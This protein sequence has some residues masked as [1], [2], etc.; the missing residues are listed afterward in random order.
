M[1]R[2]QRC[3]P[4]VNEFLTVERRVEGL[5]FVLSLLVFVAGWW[6]LSS[7]FYETAPDEHSSLFVQAVN[8]NFAQRELVAVEEEKRPLPKEPEPVAQPEEVDV[9]LEQVVEVPEVEPDP[10]PEPEKEVELEPLLAEAQVWQE[11]S[12][13]QEQVDFNALDQWIHKEIDS[14]K[15]YPPAAERIGL[16]GIF[17]FSLTVNSGGTIVSAEVLEGKGHRMLRRALEGMLQ[18]LVGRSFGKSIGEAYEFAAEFEFE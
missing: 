1:C 8:L 10:E 12:S 15:Y 2:L 4:V 9:V 16:T 17:D 7:Y 11:A 13:D 14:V 18:R 3:R 5:A 6:V